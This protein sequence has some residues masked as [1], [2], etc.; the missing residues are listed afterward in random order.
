MVHA[1]A[2]YC[3]VLV[4]AGSRENASLIAG[5]LIEERLAAC[6]NILPGLTSVYR[7]EGRVA[8]DEEVLLICKTRTEH[9]PQLE[10]RVR[11][12]HTYDVPEVIQLPVTAGS[13]PYLAWIDESLTGSP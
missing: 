11:D 1:D 8:E 7:W 5:T 3:V 10:R 9:F 12:L 2:T 4:T 6:C 13:A